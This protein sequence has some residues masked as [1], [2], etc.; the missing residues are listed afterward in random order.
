MAPY[1]IQPF[2]YSGWGV[3]LRYDFNRDIGQE[4]TMCRISPDCSKLFIGKGK[5]VGG[6]GYDAQNC[7]LSVIFEVHDRKDF[8]KKHIRY[9]GNH[10]PLV[11]GDYTEELE[12][13]AEMLG[14]EAVKAY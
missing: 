6:G 10:L 14:L 2:A 7:S 4:I 8:F 1:G 11:Y 12:I 5:I 3:T 13:L 9:G